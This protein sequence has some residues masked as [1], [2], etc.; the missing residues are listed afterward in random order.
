MKTFKKQ[1]LLI[2]VA[3]AILALVGC[4]DGEGPMQT[5]GKKVDTAAEKTVDTTKSVAE[6]TGH[7]VKGAAEVTGDAV[8]GAAEA[9]GD[10]V[11]GA[12]EK[13]GDAVNNT[14]N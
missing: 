11:K 6:T 12:A 7:A 5:A 1:L 8:K 10:A 14:I 3:L 2:L 9:T 4:D 13:T